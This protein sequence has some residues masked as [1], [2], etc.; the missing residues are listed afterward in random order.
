MS[1]CVYVLCTLADVVDA[2]RG[3]CRT[4]CDMDLF[5]NRFMFWQ[6]MVRISTLVLSRA[7]FWKSFLGESDV[8]F[9]S[10]LMPL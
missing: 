1:L 5:T 6:C 4:L 3:F 10:H 8:A 9:I 2:L 7:E